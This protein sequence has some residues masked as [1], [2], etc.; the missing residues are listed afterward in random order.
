MTALAHV[1]IALR[2]PDL[3]AVALVC[4]CVTFALAS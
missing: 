2:I 3:V 1:C 4:G